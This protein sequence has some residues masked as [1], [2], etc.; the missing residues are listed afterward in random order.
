[1]TSLL[2]GASASQTALLII[3]LQN[4]FCAQGG[5]LQKAKNYDVGFAE[6]VA[7]NIERLLTMVRKSEATVIW[8][9]SIYDFKYL[10][11]AHIA[12]RGTEGCCLEGTWGSDF[13]RLTPD[14]SDPVFTKHTFSGFKKTALNDYLTDHGI[15]TLA[16]AGVATNVCVDSTLRDAFFSGYHVILLEDCVGSN[17]RAGHEGTIATVRTNFGTVTN[18]D[19]FVDALCSGDVHAIPPEFP[20]TPSEAS[21]D[22]DSPERLE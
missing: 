5:F 20:Y 8:I 13:Y 16:F 19:E 12:Q 15:K 18:A 6:A 21:F 2:R 9:R 4:D 7:T 14:D 1:M 22:H 17:N 10:L 3:D 11:D